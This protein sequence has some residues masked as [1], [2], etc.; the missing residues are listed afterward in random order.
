VSAAG[1]YD[2]LRGCVVDES[3]GTTECV[4]CC[5]RFPD[6]DMARCSQCGGDY[7]EECG[8]PVCP[9]LLDDWCYG[10]ADGPRLLGGP[11]EPW[12]AVRFRRV[13]DAIRAVFTDEREG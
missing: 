1:Y 10:C 11:W 7:C 8:A 6:D 5:E 4:V 2:P 9:R 3:A 12:F 13:V